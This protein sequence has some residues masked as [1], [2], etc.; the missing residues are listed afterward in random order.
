MRRL[1]LVMTLAATAGAVAVIVE[2]KVHM[3]RV[4]APHAPGAVG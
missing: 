1:A 2:L 3:L 4:T